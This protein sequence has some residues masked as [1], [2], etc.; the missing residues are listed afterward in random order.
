[1]SEPVK[2]TVRPNGPLRVEGAIVLS[3]AEG[4][5][6][7]L[8]GKPAVSLCRC[9]ASEKRPFCDGSH[10]RIEFQ[11]AASP[12]P[13]AGPG[14]CRPHP[15]CRRQGHLFLSERLSLSSHP[16]L[17][18]TG[19]HSPHDSHRWV[20]LLAAWFAAV[21]AGLLLLGDGLRP[22]W[23]QDAGSPSGAGLAQYEGQYRSPSDPDQVHAVYLDGGV[24]YEESE[25]R[26]R[27]KLTPDS[28]DG[29][30]DRFRVDSP[31]A[32]VLFR[33]DASGAISGLKVVLDRDGSTLAEE[34]FST[35]TRLSHFR[36]YTRQEAMLPMR[37]GARLH[38]VILRPAN[39][40][41][42]RPAGLP[43]LLNRTPYGVDSVNSESLNWD[44]PELAASGYIFVDQDIRGRYESDGKFV[45][46]RPIV[47]HNRTAMWMRPPTRRTPSTGC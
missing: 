34:R 14:L 3:D 23:A 22:V 30:A 25:R 43:F 35:A 33:R 24:L 10:R 21:L 41:D 47:A 28:A 1:M 18:T 39:P 36:E 31:N 26:A 5:Q 40:A 29:T 45:M 7:D 11:C 6:W 12:E 38:A 13:A 19:R 9:G 8:T 27:Q 20:R 37:D 16:S 17:P 15:C 44:K 46:N 4:R 2:I 32:H 42:V